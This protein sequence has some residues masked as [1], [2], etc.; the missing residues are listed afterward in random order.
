VAKPRHR[1]RVPTKIVTRRPA[2]ARPSRDS[3]GAPVDGRRSG[4]N[5]PFPLT[6]VREKR[7]SV[8]RGE[9]G[10]NDQAARGVRQRASEV[11]HQPHTRPKTPRRGGP[12]LRAGALRSTPSLRRRGCRESA[13]NAPKLGTAPSSALH[14]GLGRPSPLGER[15][16]AGAAVVHRSRSKGRGSRMAA[17][18]EAQAF[19]LGNQAIHGCSCRESVA[20]V[21]EEHLPRVTKGSREANRGGAR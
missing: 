8:L 12:R 2:R 6:R 13:S 21:G 4:S 1:W 20:E 7:S 9:P 11:V 16:R 14:L 5:K 18:G 15:K 3:S 17:V 19:A 10:R